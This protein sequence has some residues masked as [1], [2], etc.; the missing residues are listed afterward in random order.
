MDRF[1]NFFLGLFLAVGLIGAVYLG[2]KGFVEVKTQEQST[3]TVT[4]SA[5]RQIRSDYV[6]WSATVTSEASTVAAAYQ[7]LAKQMPVVTAYLAKKGIAQQQ[8]QVTSIS[9]IVLHGHDKEGRELPEV[10]TGYTM[11]QS[12]EVR[13]NEVDK[14]SQIAR[15]STELINEGVMIRSSTP[16]YLYT[17]LGDLKI[18]MLEEAAKDAKVRA[19]KIAASTGTHIGKLRSARMGVIQINAAGENNTS[20]VG[21]NDTSSIEKDVMTVVSA[22]FVLE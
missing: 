3:I 9:T 7:Q 18:A 6:I 1:G 15:E 14:I 8:L 16:Q 22:S 17:K 21:V 11:Y 19:E 13:S 5:K 2:T 20:D 4:G 12:V 10:V